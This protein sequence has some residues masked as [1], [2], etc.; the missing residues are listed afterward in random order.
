MAWLNL[1]LVICFSLWCLFGGMHGTCGGRPGIKGSLEF[2]GL[3][4]LI[5]DFDGRGRPSLHREILGR[6]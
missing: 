1:V 2:G 5:R 4:F 6:K 3:I